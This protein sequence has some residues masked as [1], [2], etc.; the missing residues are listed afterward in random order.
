MF[1]PLNVL[2]HN[3]LFKSTLCEAKLPFLF[4]FHFYLFSGK[5]ALFLEKNEERR[6]KRTKRK[7]RLCDLSFWLGWQ[8]SN[9]RM[10]QS[11]C[12]VLPLDDTPM[13]QI[14]NLDKGCGRFFAKAF[15]VGGK[16]GFEPT[17]SSATNWRFNLLSYNH[18][19]EHY[20]IIIK[21]FVKM[22]L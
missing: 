2:Y 8:D 13:C 4:S 14:F 19:N 7:S 11:K 10:Q 20:Y 3:S 22:F 17:V 12:C 5:V 15:F 1:S 16:M 6:V 18:R 9:L 21:Q